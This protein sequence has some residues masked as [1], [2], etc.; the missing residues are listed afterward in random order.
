MILTT[1]LVLCS[2][3]SGF[4]Q[5]LSPKDGANQLQQLGTAIHRDAADLTN[6]SIGLSRDCASQSAY[7]SIIS[8][9]DLAVAYISGTQ[10]ML[11]LYAVIT[12][13]KDRATATPRVVSNIAKT[14][15]QLAIAVKGISGLFGFSDL[16][17]AAATLVT[18]MQDNVR[19][20][21]SV[22][23]RVSFTPPTGE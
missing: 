19:S 10:D 23:D 17:S 21:M 16:P 8:N 6:M 5:A 13:E 12:A 3:A 14:R 18:R 1:V 2:A 15:Q 4:A 20:A 11:D 7:H 22:L 9:A